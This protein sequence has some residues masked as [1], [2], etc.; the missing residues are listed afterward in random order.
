MAT[1][2][3]NQVSLPQRRKESVLG[4]IV[5]EQWPL[6]RKAAGFSFVASILVI[7][8]SIFM[9]EVYDRV[10]N[11]RNS[12]TLLML[13][14]CV[15]G[16]YVLME[17]IEY[18]RNRILQ[19]AGWKIDEA[20]RDRIHDA[21]YAHTLRQGEGTYPAFND[22]KT[23]REFISSPAVPALLELPSSLLFLLVVFLISPWLGGIALAGAMIQVFLGLRA[24]KKIA[25]LLTE[26]IQASTQA[27]NYAAGV[28]R[29]AQVIFAMGMR[30]GIY[31]RWI[32]RQRNFL[33]L[34]ARASDVAGTNSASSKFIQTMQQSLILGASCL[35]MIKGIILIG[36]G[37][38]IFAS[39]LGGRV[40]SP[41]VQLVSQWR[42]VVTVRDAYQRLD[43]FL[44]QSDMAQ[45][46]M[47]LP[48]PKGQLQVEGVVAMAPGSQT[49]ILRG[50]SFAL[51]AGETLVVIGPSGAGKTTLARVLMGI[52][53]AAGGK[54]RLDGAD[55]HQWNKTELGPHLGYLPQAIEL[56][57][58]TLAEN[59]T[60]F[61]EVDETHLQEVGELA[62]LGEFVKLL[63]QAY[64]TPVGEEGSFLSG[65]QRQRVGIA[66]AIYGRPKF[67]VLDEPNSNLDEVGEKALMNVLEARKRQLCTTIIIT[68]RASL[69]PV[70]DKIMVLRD[71]QVA[72]F[73]PREEVL[74]ALRRPAPQ[75]VGGAA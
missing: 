19:I 18:V 73:G 57:D 24:E 69:L 48:M 15:L 29:N 63:P 64:G 41:M 55:I 35:L 37:V 54:V 62:G 47:P 46:S 26:A 31:Q 28:L 32:E 12:G 10:V 38:M 21:V 30:D 25:P 60:R 20:L 22:L 3:F 71:G 68:H 36:G 50:V 6:L 8:P 14:L 61:G 44:A 67:V 65:G 59:I 27:Q 72:A 42:Q 43:I 5:L 56:L 66:R 53:P 52:W 58:G 49:S 40:L 51:L 4:K 23:V 11:S 17:V 7:A 39:T 75:P 2:N 33:S 34:Q 9:L 74:A 45:A 70:A 13:L 1:M 16:V